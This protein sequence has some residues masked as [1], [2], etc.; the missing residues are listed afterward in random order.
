MNSLLAS[1]Q[2]NRAM[3]IAMA[4]VGIVQVTINE[5][6]YVVSMGNCFMPT[7][8]SMDM[9]SIMTRAVMAVSTCIWIHIGHL[10]YVLIDMIT[11]GMVKMPIMEIVDVVAV[12]DGCVTTVWTMDVIVILMNCAIHLHLQSL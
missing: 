10:D 5:I 8:R 4:I 9:V 12:L 7:A 1:H 2:L 6:A 3:V 11:M